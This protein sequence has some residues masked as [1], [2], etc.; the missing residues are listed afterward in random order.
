MKR[1]DRPQRAAA[2]RYVA[3][4][5]KV[6]AE[7]ELELL[8]ARGM[9]AWADVLQLSIV[10]RIT[11]GG[12]LERADALNHV[13][14][15]ARAWQVFLQH[16][17][18]PRIA[19]LF[20]QAFTE[21]RTQLRALTAAGAPDDD[22]DRAFR[23]ELDA[24]N[25]GD[26]DLFRGPDAQAYEAE[27]EALFGEEFNSER[28]SADHSAYRYEQEHIAT[29][30]DRLVIWPDGAWEEMRPEIEEALAEGESINQVRDRIAH[31][32]GTDSETRRIRADIADVDRE[33]MR[34]D[35]TGNERAELQA[36]RRDLW[37]QHDES[38]DDWEYN[39]RRVART[40]VQG[41]VEG[42]HDAAAYAAQAETGVE[43]WKRWLAT[44]DD[45]TRMSH[46]VA[47]GQIV[48]LDEKF[49]VGKAHLDHPADPD[50][51]VAGEIINCRCTCLYFPWGEVQEEIAG[52][53]GS[54]GEVRPR[55]VRLGPDDP[56]DVQTA[57]EAEKQAQREWDAENSGMTAAGRR[58]FN[59]GQPRNENG[60]W[61]LDL[62]GRS[63]KVHRPRR[64]GTHPEGRRRRTRV[65]NYDALRGDFHAPSGPDEVAPI[66]AD[67]LAYIEDGHA[68]GVNLPGQSE[69][70][71][72]WRGDVL[73][74]K[75][76]QV[77]DN[78]QSMG[79]DRRS[80]RAHLYGMVDGIRVK[81]VL[82][83]T[84]KGWTPWSVWTSY[85]DGKS[86]I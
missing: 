12:P 40:E 57:I 29:V 60:E 74:D 11:D 48:K 67:T 39:A 83:D 53:E 18:L 34:T 6:R 13:D 85:P 62:G 82:E 19:A 31:V 28:K 51:L 56:T 75:I 25:S 64:G 78:P 24:L 3:Y 47:D 65:E 69:F 15:A 2:A 43:L 16:G 37:Q 26:G 8:I 4:T 38:T 66:S 21:Q 52:E 81:V 54:L 30:H 35:L 7:A 36:R 80:N 46:R 77:I 10:S 68:H 1:A 58:G 76:E 50:G 70:P 71:K 63:P 33:L 73:R 84:G 14:E 44:P 27:A 49:T 86:I 55:G 9:D 23:A 17:L 20:R 45:R 79:P 41:A 59:P 5:R 61:S 42:G 32:I 22:F 72:G